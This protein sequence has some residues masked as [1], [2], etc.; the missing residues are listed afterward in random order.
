[1]PDLKISTH[2]QL[3]L[4]GSPGQS[5][6]GNAVAKF[7]ST[8][9]QALLYYLAVTGE[10]HRRAA[11]AT[12]FW[13]N[14]SESKANTS[15]RA[16][17]SSLRKAIPEQ[18]IV[19]RHTVTLDDNL[20]WV[21]TQQ[22]TR[23][24]QEMDDATLTMQQRQAAVSLY[25]GDFLEGFHVDDAPDF[26]HWVTSMREYFQQA[27][28]HA[29]MELARWHVTHHDQA[30]SLAAL[31]RLLALAPGNEAGH[32]LMMQVLTHTGQRTAAI[33]QFDTLRRYLVEELGIDP[34]PET[35][36]LY[37]QLLEGNSVD[38]KSEVSVTT[39]PSAQ[40]PPGLGSMRAIQ[41]DW[42]DM[43]G[44]TPFHGRIHQLTE[45]INRLVRERAKVVVVS[46]MGGVGKTA[47]AAELVYRLV[48]LPAAQTRFT[49]IV[50]RSLVNAPA[51]NTLLDDW[52]RTLAPAPAAR[53]PE[54]LDAKLERLFVELGKRR[55]LLL[56][57][58]LESIM[59]TGEQAGEFRA[60]FE[61]YRQLLERMAHGHHQSCLLITTR[62]VPRGIR[63][64]ETDYAHVYH[65][66]LRGLLPD[67][68]MV[69]LRHRAIK[70]SSGALHVLIDHYSGNPLA[71]KLVASTVNEL[72]A[73]DIERFLREGALIFDDVRSV[74]D[75]QFD[76]LSTLARDLLIWL[77]VNR[78]PVELDDL[79]HD[80]VVPASTRPLLEAIRSLRRASLLQELS[81]KIV[82]TGVDG[83]GGVRLSLH[84]VVMEYIADH[85]LGA[86]QAELNEGRVDYFHR[87]ALRKVSAQEYVQSAQTRLFLAPLVQ[88]LLDYEG[89]LGAQQRLRRLLDCARADS[90]LAK[91]YMGTNVIHLMLQLSPQLQSEDFSGL[92]LRQA[93]LRAASLIDVDL[94][95]TDLSSTRFADSFGIVTSVAV[96]PDGQFLAAGAGRSLVVWRLQTLQL[97]MS[98]KEHPRNIAQIAFAPDGR[99][100]AS[101]D[102]E[103]IILVWDLVAGHLVNRF[104]SHV[105]DLLSIAFSPDGE[106]LVGGG[107]NGRIGL[108]NWRRGEVLDTLAPEERILALAFALTGELLVNIGYYGEIQAWN[109]HTHQIIYTL[110]NE[111][112]VYV[113]HATLVVGRA[114]IWSH[115]GDFILAW[116]RNER[117]LSFVLGG[118]KSWIDSLALSPGE[119]QIASADADGAIMLWDVQTR[120]P[121]RLLQGHQGSIRTLAYTPDGRYLISGAYDETVRIW[122]LQ[123]G[124]E[125]ARL[126][127]HAHWI[128]LLAFSP[129]GHYLAGVT[130]TG[131]IYFWDGH[132]LGLRHV[133]QGHK[134]AIRALA[135]SSDSR[136]FATGSDDNT[137]II[138]DVQSG[139][140][141]HTLRGHERYVRLVAFD[142]SGRYL[143][144]SSY[145]DTIRLWDVTTGH[146]LNVVARSS[147][148][149]MEWIAFHPHQ[150]LLA[151]TDTS[152]RIYLWDVER[153]RV[154]VDVA[155]ASQPKMLAFSP[156]GR[157][158]VCGAYDGS[159]TLW[160]LVTDGSC[161]TLAEHSRMQ[162]SAQSAWALV[163]SQNSSLLAWNGEQREIYVTSVMDGEALCSIPGTHLAHCIA[164]S[165]DGQYLM[166]DGP[167][168]V[169][170][171]YNAS[172]GD[173][174]KSLAGHTANLT[175]IVAS[176]VASTIASTDSGGVVKLWDVNTGATLATAQLNGPYLGMNITNATGLT[177]GQRQSLLALG[178]VDVP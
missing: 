48:E 135:F 61:S 84:N 143:A 82:A 146:L 139:E 164:I 69:L 130:L 40:F 28:I 113:T 176:P 163:F 117:S 149:T 89:H 94:R 8:K 29:L 18:L 159:V 137:V 161:V 43:P 107:Y 60:G 79:A 97:T 115:Q 124:L 127:G 70:G 136:L 170:A 31:S 6:G 169:V 151:Y 64:L 100:L 14:V 23:L 7:R 76:R 91:G 46:G 122:D 152:N 156:D 9:T 141:R 3:R 50:W 147:G 174:G 55:V 178:A 75:Q 86:F 20:V 22:F 63:R 88:W 47:L 52:L 134:S 105:G 34:E 171:S 142:P 168:F 116:D 15:L 119:D 33:L 131:A 53:L 51:L 109:I 54:N 2:L 144:S 106:T 4:L 78:G 72:Y 95:N 118:S 58:N 26:D 38:P 138:W 11:L 110:R 126:Q 68:G 145:D 98:F 175:S 41:T 140:L 81:P 66:P 30:A 172:T 166:T 132:N 128:Y 165:A 104:K 83:S 44:R 93:D 99:H 162:P 37:A 148:N 25:V 16:A 112:P 42:G 80:L 150:P 5:I 74:L 90:A 158:L 21:D 57:D 125:E 120:Q 103:G 45:I 71:L 157:Y 10:T 87:Y 92:N 177:Q 59:A 129:N 160:E 65:L 27:M 153:G 1:M 133:R 85:L 101:A 12:L 102:F 17:L 123:N 73:G 77:T 108:W 19:D 35:M 13:P 114:F 56:L 121:Q 67:E 24:L 155:T 96:S 173:A 49:D 32:R 111:N 39:V 154:A 36:A 62:V 167:E